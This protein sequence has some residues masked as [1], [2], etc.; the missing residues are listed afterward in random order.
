MSGVPCKRVSTDVNGGGKVLGW[1][2]EVKECLS[3]EVNKV[4]FAGAGRG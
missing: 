2:G 3:S 1:V 4:G